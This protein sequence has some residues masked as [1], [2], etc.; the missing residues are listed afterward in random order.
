MR[1]LAISDI[2]GCFTALETLANFA[3]FDRDDVVITL[4]DYVDKGPDTRR[5]LDWLIDYQQRGRLVPIRGNHD[6]MMLGARDSKKNFEDWFNEGGNQTLKSYGGDLK[7]VPDS[8]W[9]F[10]EATE[11][12]F[13]IET[14]FFVHANAWPD[15]PLDE[16]PDF[17][18][19]WEFFNDPAPHESG[20]TMVCGHTSQRSFEPVNIGH[21]ICI[22]T[23]CFGGGWLSCLDITSGDLWQANERG[24]TQQRN[25]EEYLRIREE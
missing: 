5:A 10:L 16:Q 3:R 21:A 9:Q 11:R 14:H 25:I 7:S 20:K 22:D 4:G 18:L 24:E 15:L 23:R 13:E 17:M 12:Y 8:H 2:H 19:F 6:I 1:Y